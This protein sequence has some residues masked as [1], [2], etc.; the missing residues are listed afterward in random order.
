[1]TTPVTVTTL[2]DALA[3]IARGRTDC[4]RPLGGE[5]AR[6][7]ARR[8]LLAVGWDWNARFMA[9]CRDCPQVGKPDEF[10]YDDHGFAV[11]KPCMKKRAVA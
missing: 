10:E 11:C 7:L 8:T 4:G 2:Y 1:M 3:E 6:K 5:T 9:R